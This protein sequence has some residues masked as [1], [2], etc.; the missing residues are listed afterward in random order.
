MQRGTTR[1]KERF[2]N[3]ALSQKIS[4][5]F[6]V[7][8]L[9]SSMQQLI[10]HGQLSNVFHLAGWIT[11]LVF[12]VFALFDNLVVRIVQ[13]GGLILLSFLVITVTR[14]PSSLAAYVLLSI[15]L[16]AAYKMSLFGRRTLPVLFIIVGTAVALAVISGTMYGF[17]MMQR[18]NIVNFVLVYLALLFFIFEEETLS[19]RRQRDTLTRQAGELKPFATLGGN[20]AGLVHDFK[21]DVAGLYALASIE[22]MTDNTETADRIERYADRLNR[23]V[24]SILFVATAA[25]HHE[26]EP[27]DLATVLQHVVYYF[28]EVN[29][30]LKHKVA[31]NLE[32]E[33]ELTVVTR[34]NALMVVLENVIRNSIEATE[35]YSDRTVSI[36]GTRDD[37]GTV[38]ITIS[39]NGNHLPRALDATGTVDVRRSDYFKRGK[40]DRPGGTGLGMINV[41]RALEVADAQ[42]HMRNLA[43][44]VESRIVFPPAQ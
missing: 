9:V 31:I 5:T 41:I 10:D 11:M 8:F 15:G 16:A 13:A 34:R 7:F 28:I 17:S 44:G 20:I 35:G 30:D 24:E 23:R 38:S 27:L 14:S 4:L 26:P 37:D 29:R 22:R 36:A 25:N 21:G 12:L 1:L 3:L 33:P 40:S 43:A 42:L 39:H 18:L 6:A 19:L 32:V 2:T